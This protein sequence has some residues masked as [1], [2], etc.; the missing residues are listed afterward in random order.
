MHDPDCIPD[1]VAGELFLGSRGRAGG[2]PRL[3]PD[4]DHDQHRDVLC[5][6]APARFRAVCCRGAL[7][8]GTRA[9]RSTCRTNAIPGWGARRRRLPHHRGRRANAT[10]VLS[11]PRGREEASGARLV[12]DGGLPVRVRRRARL[13][14]RRAR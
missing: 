5:A 12:V 2:G 3:Q 13:Q 4:S 11:L 1:R 10:G 8:R 6:R 14:R 9:K 7:P